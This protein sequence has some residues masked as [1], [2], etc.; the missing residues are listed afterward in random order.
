VIAHGPTHVTPAHLVAWQ[1]RWYSPAPAD[2]SPVYDLGAVRWCCVGRDLTGS[3]RH[4]ALE[5]VVREGRDRERVHG[6]LLADVVIA[7]CV[8]GPRGELAP[9]ARWQV[10]GLEPLK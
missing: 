9:V 1:E 7:P 6:D 10:R 2:A 4:R 3:P 5:Y 8:A